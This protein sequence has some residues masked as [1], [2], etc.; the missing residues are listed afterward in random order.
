MDYLDEIIKRHERE[1]ALAPPS[2]S[3]SEDED[4]DIG[5]DEK[6]GTDGILN[7]VI[8]SHSQGEPSFHWD[9]PEEDGTDSILDSVIQENMDFPLPFGIT[10]EG[11]QP[12]SPGLFDLAERAATERAETGRGDLS[13]IGALHERRTQEDPLQEEEEPVRSERRGIFDSLLSEEED[14]RDSNDNPVKDKNPVEW[15]KVNPLHQQQIL[16]GKIPEW[17]REEDLDHWRKT[18]P[19]DNDSKK[20]LM[21][22]E[23]KWI[24]QDAQ[25]KSE[26]GYLDSFLAG[27]GEFFGTQL[28]QTAEWLGEQNNIDWLKDKGQEM[29]EFGN[30]VTETFPVKDI[31]NVTLPRIAIDLAKGDTESFRWA[32]KNYGLRNAALP[33]ATT[34]MAIATGW[35]LPAVAG[36]APG[37]MLSATAPAG[38]MAGTGMELLSNPTMWKEAFKSLGQLMTSTSL[39][40]ATESAIEGGGVYKEQVQELMAKGMSEEEAKLKG[41]SSA[42]ATYWKNM[43]LLAGSNA[44][45]HGL[46]TGKL[47]EDPRVLGSAKMKVK[48]I[49]DEMVNA[50][51]EGGEE[52]S[53]RWA[54]ETSKGKPFGMKELLS[55]ETG[56][57]F[58]G[59]VFMA[60]GPSIVTAPINVATQKAKSKLAEHTQKN[61]DKAMDEA[62]NDFQRKRAVQKIAIE[63]MDPE[64]HGR[65]ETF[66][67]GDD[68][69]PSVKAMLEDRLSFL[70]EN[71]TDEN[72]VERD[73]LEAKLSQGIPGLNALV[74][75]Y[76]IKDRFNALEES[77]AVEPE[78]DLDDEAMAFGPEN[79]QEDVQKEPWEMTRDEWRSYKWEKI[80]KKA[81]RAINNGEKDYVSLDKIWEQTDD[82]HSR[83][84]K[85]ALSEGKTVPEEVLKDYPELQKDKGKI[86]PKEPHV[87]DE[88]NAGTQKIIDGTLTEEEAKRHNKIAKELVEDAVKQEDEID[89]FFDDLVKSAKDPKRAENAVRELRWDAKELYSKRGKI[90]DTVYYQGKPYVIA[91]N[92]G[93]DNYFLKDPSTGKKRPISKKQ[94]RFTPKHLESEAEGVTSEAP[95]KPISHTDK[96]VRE[97]SQ[98][99]TLKGDT[100]TVINRSGRKKVGEIKVSLSE[101]EDAERG[102]SAN[103]NWNKRKLVEKKFIEAFPGNLEDGMITPLSNRV[104]DSE[105]RAI[106][107][108]YAG[109][110]QENKTEEPTLKKLESATKTIDD[111]QP[112]DKVSRKDNGQVL[113]VVENKGSLIKV[114]HPETGAEFQMGKLTLEPVSESSSNVG[115]ESTPQEKDAPETREY[116]SAAK[117]GPSEASTQDLGNLPDSILSVA[118]EFGVMEPIPLSQFT[119][120][121]REALEQAGLVGEKRNVLPDGT[122]SEPF[123]GVDNQVLM[124]ERGRRGPARTTPTLTEEGRKRLE[125]RE[126][127]QSETSTEDWDNVDVLDPAVR[128]R[129]NMRAIEKGLPPGK[130]ASRGTLNKYRRLLDGEKI[131]LNMKEKEDLDEHFKYFPLSKTRLSQ[132]KTSPSNVRNQYIAWMEDEGHKQEKKPWEMTYE[133]Y[134]SNTKPPGNNSDTFAEAIARYRKNGDKP[135]RNKEI[136]DRVADK[137]EAQARKMHE[138]HVKGA[139][140]QGKTVPKEV[141]ADYPELQDSGKV[142]EVKSTTPVL[143]FKEQ[144]TNAAKYAAKILEKFDLR[145]KVMDGNEFYGKIKLGEGL[146]D[147]VIERHINPVSEGKSAPML[148]FT[149]YY[150]QNGDH[151]M[152][153][154]IVFIVRPD[155]RLELHETMTQNPSTGGEL[156]SRGRNANR[157]YAQTVMKNNLTYSENGKLWISGEEDTSSEKSGKMP[158]EPSTRGGTENERTSIEGKDRN[159]VEQAG[160]PHEGAPSE[161]VQ[162]PPEEGGAGRVHP[163]KGNRRGGDG[164]SSNGG[165]EG[166]ESAREEAPVPEEGPDRNLDPADGVGAD[167]GSDPDAGGGRRVSPGTV[168]RLEE[169]KAI[170]AGEL[171]NAE[172]KE[173]A[174]LRLAQRKGELKTQADIVKEGMDEA[175]QALQRAARIFAEHKR[176]GS[177][178]YS[179][180]VDESLY[181]QIKPELVTAWEGL[182]K[183]GKGAIDLMDMALD[184]MGDSAISYI[185]RFV[186]EVAAPE[187]EQPK[188]A[189]TPEK[190]ETPEKKAPEKKKP[191][192][193]KA[194]KKGTGKS[195]KTDKGTNYQITNSDKLGEGGPKTRIANNLAAIRLAKK[196]AS[197]Q[198][199]AT[200]EEQKALVKYVGWGGLSQVF[201]EYKHE[202][203]KERAEL[204]EILTDKEYQEA[205]SSTKNAHYTDPI[206]I[207]AMWNALEKAGFKGGR[208]LDPS[209]GTG[210]F[211]GSMPG[212]IAAT[213]TLCGVELDPTTGLLGKLLY[214][215]SDVKVQGF[216]ETRYPDDYFDLAISNVPF[217]NYRVNDLKFNKYGFQIH[218]YFFAKAMSKVRPGGLIA[219]ITGTGTMQGTTDAK[220][221]RQLLAKDADLVCAVRLP[222]NAFKAIAN[223][224]VTT[225]II[226]LRKKDPNSDFKGEPWLDV[227]ESDTRNPDA[228]ANFM[229]NEYFMKHPE[230][231]LGDMV[232]DKLAGWGERNRLGLKARE[233]QDLKKELAK[234]FR[235]GIPK[236]IFQ[237]VAQ[238]KVPEIEELLADDQGTPAG[239]FVDK[240]GHIYQEENGSLKLRQDL[241]RKD[242]TQIRSFLELHEITAKLI[243][244]QQTPGSSDG[245]LESLRK[246]L[247]AVYDSYVKKYGNLSTGAGSKLVSADPRFFVISSLE[248][249]E[250]LPRVK[251]EKK[252]YK[253]TKADIFRQRTIRPFTETTSVDTEEEALAT[254][255]NERGYIDLARMGELLGKSPD[256]IISTLGDKIYKDPVKDQWQTSDEYLSGDV[257]RKLA[258]AEDVAQRDPSIKRNV[259][260]L[261][262]VIPEDIPFDKIKIQ[263]GSAWIQEETIQDF[264]VHLL[265]K[266]KS[267]IRVRFVHASGQWLLDVDGYIDQV[268]EKNTWG[269]P[270]T[271]VM[272]LLDHAFNK[273]KAK[274]TKTIEK[275]DGSKRTVVD[276]DSSKMANEKLDKIQQ[277]FLAW[278]GGD[279]KRKAAIERI[280]NDS[281]NNWVERKYD[282]SHLTCPGMHSSLT[283]RPWQASAVWRILQGGNHLLA[284]VMGAGKTLAMQAAGMELKRLGL[285][286]KPMYVCPVATTEQFY[287]DFKKAYPGARILKISNADL[288][289]F[290]AL[291]K[292]PIRP[293]APKKAPNAYGPP[294]V[295]AKAQAKYE[296]DMAAWEKEMREYNRKAKGNKAKRQVALNKIA[297]NDWDAIVIARTTFQRIPVSDDA[298]RDFIQEQ[299]DDYRLLLAAVTA[300]DEGS[301]RRKSRSVKEVEKMV[302]NF[303]AKLE[304]LEGEEHKD[305]SIPF[306]SLGVDYLF[307]DEAHGYKN[308]MFPTKMSDVKGVNPNNKTNK[309][310]KPPQ[311]WDMFMKSR[312]LSERG[313][314]RGIIFATGTP[315][316]NAAAE[317]W[318]M[319]RYLDHNTLEADSVASFDSWAKTF[320]SI[321]T[322]PEQ[323]VSGQWEDVTRLGSYDNVPELIQRFR[324]VAD[325]LTM[326]DMEQAV[327]DNPEALKTLSLPEAEIITVECEKPRDM[328][329]F[330]MSLAERLKA[331]KGRRAEKGMDNALV[332]TGDMKHGSLDLRLIWKN[333]EVDRSAKLYVAIDRAFKIWKDTAGRKCAQMIFCD[334]S[335][336]SKGNKEGAKAING[337]SVYQEIKDELVRLGV[338]EKEIAFIHDAADGEEKALLADKLNRGE[339][340]FLLGSTGTLGTGVNAQKNLLAVHHLDCPWRPSDMEQRDGRIIRPGNNNKKVFVFRYITKGSGDSILW[341]R[342]AGK[343][344]LIASVMKGDP[345]IRSLEEM[346]DETLGFEETSAMAHDDLR[347]LKKVELE[348]RVADLKVSRRAWQKSMADIRTKIQTAEY[349]IKGREKEIP[350]LEKFIKDL[351]ELRENFSIT[352]GDVEYTEQGEAASALEEEFV[353]AAESLGYKVERIAERDE[354]KKGWFQD[355]TFTL[356]HEPSSNFA[357]N[358]MSIGEIMGIPL[359]VESA[360]DFV[361]NEEKEEHETVY[362]PVLRITH[363][364]QI[365][366]ERGV[367]PKTINGVLSALTKA[368]ESMS[369]AK[370]KG[371]IDHYKHK[372]E[373]LTANIGSFE[374]ADELE[375]SEQ[376]LEELTRDIMEHPVLLEGQ[377]GGETE[378]LDPEETPDI[379]EPSGDPTAEVEAR[380]NGAYEEKTAPAGMSVKILHPDSLI[381]ALTKRKTKADMDDLL[382]G[383]SKA[384]KDDPRNFEYDDPDMEKAHQ[385]YTKGIDKEGLWGK[386]IEWF[387]DLKNRCTRTFRH[388]PGGARYA[389][390]RHAL[391][392]LKRTVPTAQSNAEEKIRAILVKENEDGTYDQFDKADL[393]LFTRKVYLEDFARD[394]KDNMPLPAGFTPEGVEAELKRLNDHLRENAPWIFKSY[395]LRTELWRQ[396]KSDYIY[397]ARRAGTDMSRKFTK[398]DTY[399]RHQVLAHMMDQGRATSGAG[400]RLKSPV[401]R[402]FLKERQGSELP[403]NLN[404]A[405]AEF[406]VLAQILGDTHVWE[407][408][409]TIDQSYSI[410]DRLK[411]L[412]VKMNHN[413]FKG[414]LEAMVQAEQKVQP[415]DQRLDSEEIRQEAQKRFNLLAQ[416]QAIALSRLSSLAAAGELPVGPKG[417]FSR[418]V[419]DLAEMYMLK[420]EN[421]KDDLDVNSQ[422]D[423]KELMKYLSWLAEQEDDG[424]ETILSRTFFKG[425]AEKKKAISAGLKAAGI[426]E[427]SWKDLIP[428]DY[429]IY[430][431]RE[432]SV[433]YKAYTIPEEMAQQI[434][435]GAL[436][437]LGLTPQDIKSV[438]TR[439]A[440]HREMVIPVELAATLEELNPMGFKERGPVS[441]LHHGAVRLVKS[442]W[443]YGPTRWFKF[444]FR[445]MTGD[446]EALV[447]G[448]H[449]DALRLKHLRRAAWELS[450]AI[451]A[452]RKPSR[453]FRD[454]ADMGGF[455]TFD[456]IQE[457]GDLKALESLAHISD[458]NLSGWEKVKDKTWDLYW[459]TIDKVDSVREGILRYASYLAYLEQMKSNKE[460][461]PKNFGASNREEIMALPDIKDRAFR[462]SNTLIGGYDELTE[463][464]QH[465]RDSVVWPFWAFQ[466][467][468]MKRYYWT[469]KNAVIDGKAAGKAGKK[470]LGIK[471]AQASPFVA[472]RV[473][474]F[475]IRA[476]LVWALLEAW[477]RW[478]WPEEEKELSKDVRNRPHLIVG[479]DEHG[480]VRVMTRL[481][482]LPDLLEWFGEDTPLRYAQE[483]LNGNMT[484]KDVAEEMAFGVVN[485]TVSGT[486]PY[487][488]FFFELA[489][490][491]STYPDIRRMR[492]IRDRTEYTFNW[493]GVGDIYRELSELPHRGW[494]EVL[495]RS[496][497]NKFQ[498]GEGAYWDTISRAY[499]WKEKVLHEKSE[500]F[501]DSPKSMAMYYYKQALRY[502]DKAAAEK[503]LLDY[504]KAGG[505]RKGFKQAMRWLNPLARIPK[506]YHAEF[507]QSLDKGE[508]EDLERAMKYYEDLM[509]EIGE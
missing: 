429:T 346:D 374:H 458:P 316:S 290:F 294:K 451:Y 222:G 401:M 22:S 422:L 284:H 150:D 373:D 178:G 154:E 483:W 114:K 73:N 254:T 228:Y 202:Y 347:I 439:G 47:P 11:Q 287:Q 400:K 441:K 265:N 306:E 2:F 192:S 397:Q 340:R 218:N 181:Q 95:A 82:E 321:T 219:F 129:V 65:Q 155:G 20:R 79:V 450:Q 223:T 417:K 486:L 309:S 46:M 30:K 453:E 162:K 327:R 99:A 148:F 496:L 188:K 70:E 31:G 109:S 97:N 440:R 271:G 398:G 187:E 266:R 130:P 399:F 413:S 236:D 92:F 14:R 175:T 62:F 34:A 173:M 203:D 415:K 494:G 239:G 444:S 256:E 376:E 428:D 379:E 201:D 382:T 91:D 93:K 289:D 326:E 331:C 249:A 350:R 411:K 388:L 438:L 100:I 433:F 167:T 457:L 334:L 133:E 314:G 240:D 342:V 480:N 298:Q 15:H 84:I 98:R 301:N 471:V 343:S 349:I 50:V 312:I 333:A 497:C 164:R 488:K 421:K 186:D 364:D 118:G 55:P 224:E 257:R 261:K 485:K 58:A 39:Q 423:H 80:P 478:K 432:G 465:L 359:V 90:G 509:G 174:R 71:A 45:Q 468:N 165:S 351:G 119:P 172:L 482:L 132:I 367:N 135:V 467:I 108:V 507:Y 12:R 232:P 323:N 447:L 371:E 86:K 37:A 41:F 403:I 270:D 320:C 88:Y 190:R 426:K 365:G 260:A 140:A 144:R 120:E 19:L 194:P 233:G 221:L 264:L 64:K 384:G 146:E 475:A 227:V 435:N 185:D 36:S 282:G 159:S 277:E 184:I 76:G 231:M 383:K 113:E 285:A 103:P 244:A 54:S 191:S 169:L 278:L 40:T 142:E 7:E 380:I 360:T 501:R 63:Q 504:F 337:K 358:S 269:T 205:R 243:R 136:G 237:E 267:D 29:Q 302:E 414:L 341:S 123:M 356:T 305:F 492:N 211:F 297:M 8:A 72:Q 171:T 459:R 431:P 138:T 472:M 44:I 419:E 456:R 262:R 38:A 317:L 6:L 59:G 470:A 248:N 292:K 10:L 176:R 489:A 273:G 392:Q 293:K 75:E 410:T 124:E 387:T 335:T 505:T 345:N 60:G 4:E 396:S 259:E 9:R 131:A 49:A 213:S 27:T 160:E 122:L 498:A 370:F 454:W 280:Y 226:V 74:N 51:W 430:Q 460:G 272:T 336:P 158:L 474:T 288:P 462:L 230:M 193:K 117:E 35:A 17:V 26:T 279:E 33:L 487:I 299:L 241:S 177:L 42:N 339:L 386:M 96:S 500:S 418:I 490:G 361:Y 24:Q 389:V 286:K 199:L 442:L 448:N 189:E 394:A 87:L 476:S 463:M 77:E 126:R 5:M 212:N 449:W 125:E 197:E 318:T 225:D 66:S 434:A 23:A 121:E 111:I 195:R 152:D 127:Q 304:A 48:A 508:R 200:R 3:V 332:V 69:L 461:V 68:L 252:K 319:M 94:V 214:P 246:R 53:Q 416:K 281:F 196:I 61:L 234:A 452:H 116:A 137:I 406:E 147:I 179:E 473:G 220:I 300:E 106:E 263:L 110:K 258:N 215:Q 354:K 21:I 295:N 115:P 377:T 455:M 329:S 375:K 307:V 402:G 43:L 204:K 89:K 253:I 217:G 481:G 464:G 276:V 245:E 322:K 324:K 366:V 477:N 466:E 325:I 338:P 381:E 139:L 328:P 446:T 198:R 372:I 52:V 385:A 390:A 283:L 405:Q 255:L 393:D 206:V 407:T 85:E 13:G 355:Y 28:G 291:P 409:A 210:H 436:T 209:M 493:L 163:E 437:G 166:E 83:N 153:N 503:Y 408:I 134:K 102:P 499:E 303:E 274:I 101:W 56:A 112:G 78:G 311:S 180:E 469:F 268:I 424:Q 391:L 128:E 330:M 420:K 308:L 362:T 352:L 25:K 404:Y 238:D 18:A 207:R 107:K 168:E 310:G 491:K 495:E 156:R 32:I 425:V 344:K 395:R 275:A 369:P 1:D 183:A 502:G 250:A 67:M 368:R 145:T 506:K 81:Q 247:N 363:N 412:A 357:S 208:I 251:G 16:S 315:I 216:Q 57:E 105:I 443:L 182:V 161:D 479:K 242:E 149:Q 296:K 151:V 229:L 143:S 157:S 427:L 170:P 313:N 104:I 141:L 348:S 445:N 353:K 484:V 378:S 235:K